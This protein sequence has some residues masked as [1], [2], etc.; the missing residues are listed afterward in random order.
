MSK[1]W[2]WLKWLCNAFTT[3]L[4]VLTVQAIVLVSFVVILLVYEKAPKC[5]WALWLFFSM[6][7]AFALSITYS[8]WKADKKKKIAEETKAETKAKLVR[9]L[10]DRECVPV[11][12]ELAEFA[13]S[14]QSYAE[15]EKAKEALRQLNAAYDAFEHNDKAR[16]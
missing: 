13:M 16:E 10:I 6:G 5:H 9:P 3:A 14:W 12:I 1:L 2:Y 7:I 8:S 15:D 4:A 11:L